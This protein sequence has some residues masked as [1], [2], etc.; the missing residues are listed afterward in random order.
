MV[1]RFH[2][3]LKYEEIWPNDYEDP[4]EAQMRIASYREHYNQR[5]PHQALDYGV[6]AERYCEQ[7]L[8]EVERPETRYTFVP[9]SVSLR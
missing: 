4:L 5:R 8:R 6:P 1:E 9:E 2:Q 7:A 3:G